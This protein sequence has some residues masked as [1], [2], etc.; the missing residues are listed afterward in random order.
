MPAAAR[1]DDFAP[2]AKEVRAGAAAAAAG[3][4]AAEAAAAPRT[5]A[6]TARGAAHVG[7]A[8]P[9]RPCRAARAPDAPPRAAPWAPQVCARFLDALHRYTSQDVLA[10]IRSMGPMGQGARARAPQ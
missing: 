3:A 2:Y 6:A 4:G 10:M 8:R 5:S 7:P 9:A 1:S